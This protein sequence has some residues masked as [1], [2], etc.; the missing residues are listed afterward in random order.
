MSTLTLNVTEVNVF[1]WSGSLKVIQVHLKQWFSLG[2]YGQASA[3]KHYSYIYLMRYI[4]WSLEALKLNSLEALLTIPP[5]PPS[6]SGVWYQT[7]LWGTQPEET[8]GTLIVDLIRSLLVR[9]PLNVSP[10]AGL[11]APHRWQWLLR[12]CIVL[13]VATIQLMWAWFTLIVHHQ[14]WLL[15]HLKWSLHCLYVCN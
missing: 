4:H 8:W 11:Q 10:L 9:F 3:R 6:T 15:A 12:V 1:S 7:E 2:R 13:S 5:K 14:T